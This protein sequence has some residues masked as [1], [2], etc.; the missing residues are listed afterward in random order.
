MVM[1]PAADIAPPAE[2]VN[3]KVAA[4]FAFPA[5]RSASDTENEAKLT[6]SPIVPVANVSKPAEFASCDVTTEIPAGLLAV[7]SPVSKPVKV[8]VTETL[9]NICPVP[10]VVMT[11]DVDDGAA[12]VAATLGE[13]IATFGAGQP[14]AKK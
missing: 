8:T 10:D 11:S 7:T 1:V 14:A 5:K 4:T 13:L 3:T 9:A 2:G 6:R 12:A